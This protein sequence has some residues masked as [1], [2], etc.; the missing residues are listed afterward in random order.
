M[1]EQINLHEGRALFGLN[2]AGYEDARPDYPLWIFDQLRQRGALVAGATTLEIGAGTGKA[3]RHLLEYGAKPLTIIEPDTRFAD[4]LNSTCAAASASCRI[5]YESFEDVAL[6]DYGFDLVMAA[7]SFHWIEPIAGLRKIKR[8]LTQNGVAALCWNVLSDGNKEDLF[9]DA[10]HSLL[11]PLAMGP[12]DKH[13]E[14]P[15]APDRAARQ[16]EANTAGFEHCEYFESRWSLLLS[17]RQIG[18][19][20]E[21]FSHIQRLDIDSREKL[22]NQLMT[23]ADTQFNGKVVR[24]VISCLY[25]LY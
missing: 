10:T 21:S 1:T 20:Y 16:A 4:M 15:F 11:T 13:N 2:P 23:I 12:A 8:L 19:L 3:T 22:L 17:A 14:I 24:N 7:T 6:P 9:H 18:N 25:L 5:M